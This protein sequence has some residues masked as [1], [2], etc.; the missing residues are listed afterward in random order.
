MELPFYGQSISCI[1]FTQKEDISE[2]SN[3][4]TSKNRIT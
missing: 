4:I 2:K 3:I 1:N